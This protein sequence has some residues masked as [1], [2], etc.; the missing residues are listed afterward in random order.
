AS[1]NKTVFLS[2]VRAPGAKWEAQAPR[3]W[4][5][6]LDFETGQRTR[7]LDSPADAYD[8]FVAALDDDYSQIIYT[9][10]SPAVITHAW[11]KDVKTGATKQLTHAIDASPDVTNAQHK[12]FQVTRPRDG[13]KFWVD[14]TLPKDWRPGTRLP[15][16][17]WF[18]PREYVTQA[19]YDRSK[20]ATNIN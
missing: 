10:E 1:D 11:M 3:P 8:E 2:G 7:I 19:D 12:R 9:H 14:V 18:Y 6:K 17:L 15:G 5:D 13:F 20:Y 16:I 4:V